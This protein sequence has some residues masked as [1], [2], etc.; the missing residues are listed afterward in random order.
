MASSVF[1]ISKTAA[2]GPSN[3]TEERSAEED[4][5][6][7]KSPSL[8]RSESGDQNHDQ[9]CRDEYT[10][11]TQ[12]YLGGKSEGPLAKVTPKSGLVLDSMRE[13]DVSLPRLNVSQLLF[14]IVLH[15]HG[16]KNIT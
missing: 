1:D 15:N 6:N 14:A 10:E 11:D 9:E 5:S 2:G 12:S 3:S 16:Q 7:N 13:N 8:S 4:H